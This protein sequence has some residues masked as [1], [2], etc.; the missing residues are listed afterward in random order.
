MVRRRSTVRFRNGAPVQSH[1]SN[2]HDVQVGTSGLP[3]WKISTVLGGD[4]GS[5]HAASRLEWLCGHCVPHQAPGLVAY[6]DLARACCLFQPR[7]RVDRVA[8]R[9][10]FLRANHDVPGVHA[11]ADAHGRAELASS[12]VWSRESSSPSPAAART[13]R[14]ASSSCSTGT[15]KTAI[16]ASP[17]NFSAVPP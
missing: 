9:Q 7:S 3:R 17:R 13:A 2:Q 16:T 5:R 8:G 1:N 11:D 14:S 12:W 10:A 6:D 15:P 4:Q